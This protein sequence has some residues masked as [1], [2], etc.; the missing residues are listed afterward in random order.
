MKWARLGETIADVFITISL[1][2]EWLNLPREI[3]LDSS[4]S[5]RINVPLF[6]P[7]F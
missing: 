6:T 3:F 7:V 5:V 4:C 1:C 2:I